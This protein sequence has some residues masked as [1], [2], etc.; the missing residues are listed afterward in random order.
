MRIVFVTYL[1]IDVKN[2]LKV[3]TV[4]KPDMFRSLFHIAQFRLVI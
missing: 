2:E 3:L 4:Q 1:P